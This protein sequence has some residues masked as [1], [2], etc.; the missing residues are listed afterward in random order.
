MQNLPVLIQQGADSQPAWLSGWFSFWINITTPNPQPWAYLIALT[1]LGLAFSLIFGFMRKT[2]YIVGVITS[3]VIWAVP[4]GFGGAY[5][6][7]S[8]DIG[9]GIIYAFV[10]LLLMDINAMEG[11]SK[12][13][14]DYYIEQ[15]FAF[16]KMVAEFS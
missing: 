10:F 14:L 3:L 4:E 13:S 15:R 5:G 9:T 12:I 2:G 1:E 16:W 11:P 6:P 7:T 8:T